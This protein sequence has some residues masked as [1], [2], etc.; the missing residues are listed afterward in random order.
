MSQYDIVQ[1]FSKSR[2]SYLHDI[3]GQNRAEKKSQQGPMSFVKSPSC[4][5]R[6]S[7]N[8]AVRVNEGRDIPTATRFLYTCLGTLA[9]PSAIKGRNAD[10]MLLFLQAWA[11]SVKGRDKLL[12]PKRGLSD[13]TPLRKDYR[14]T[15]SCIGDSHEKAD[16]HTFLSGSPSCLSIHAQ[17]K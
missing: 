2:P 9:V 10:S 4:C 6:F 13:W 17:A 5:V 1:A 8:R 7:S 14:S 12:Q 15:Y 16:K 11:K 3:R